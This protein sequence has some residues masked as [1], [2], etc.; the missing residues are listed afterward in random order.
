MSS[1]TPEESEENTVD[2]SN[3]MDNRTPESEM[4]RD[5]RMMALDF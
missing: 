3:N 4:I 5:D 2:G 1:K